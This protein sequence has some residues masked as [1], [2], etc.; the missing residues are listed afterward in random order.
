MAMKISKI[1]QP[2][3]I[4][5]DLVNAKRTNAI[6]EVVQQLNNHPLMINF[7]GF[8]DEV[9]ARERVESTCLGNE[10]AFPHARTDHVKNMVMAAGRSKEGVWFENCNQ[11][12]NLIFVIGTPKKMVTDYLAVVGALARLL[13]EPDLRAKLI[14]APSQQIFLEYL[15]EAECQ[16]K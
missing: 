10:V 11:K 12:V 14:A 3:M 6:H 16:L 9:L 7:Q 1:L 5:L 8:Y 15:A 2:E 13:K 4:A